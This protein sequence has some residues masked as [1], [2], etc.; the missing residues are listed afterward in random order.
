MKLDDRK[1]IWSWGLYDWANSAFATTV[2]AG[3]FPVFFKQYWSAG[4]DP[5]L[6]TARLGLANSVAGIMVALLAPLLG[7][8]ADQGSIRKKFLFFF[9]ALGVV[10]TSGL[11]L[12][13][14]GQWQFA[15][16]LFVLATV[17]F[18]GGNIFYDSLL[19]GVAS[20]KKMD[21]ISAL[22]FSLGYLGGGLLLAL[23]IS[24]ILKPS[25]FGLADTAAAVRTSFLMVAVW[26]TLFSVP[27][28]L[29]VKEPKKT[30]CRNQGMLL[31]GFQ[32]L[33]QT[34]QI[35]RKFKVLLFFLLAY[36]FYIDGVYTIVRMAVDYGLAIGL[37]ANDL[38][39][40]LL[41][42]QLV[43]FPA[44]ILFGYLGSRFGTKRAIFIAI[45]VYCA[46]TIWAA[47]MHSKHEFYL[48]A[49][50]IGLVQGGIQAL[51]RSF[52]AKLIPA[53]KSAE[54]FGFYNMVG[55][56]A[57]ILG[58]ALIGGVGLLLKTLGTSSD[59]AS[60][61][62]ITSIALLFITGGILFS[63]AKIENT[64]KK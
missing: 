28:F 3:F 47:F 29:F 33:R 40:A 41:I 59:L 17:G 11:Y 26:W 10:M 5:T 23:N 53:E 57:A 6:S 62:S 18:S 12:V 21:S 22:G 9:A 2:M 49:I 30:A 15:A 44:A 46:V 16:L 61:L 38:L 24:M 45:G 64:P 27:L 20:E 35:V 4:A 55:K 63:L 48:L 19:P 34:F 50:T 56:F 60:R 51:S 25:F 37:A 54:Y 32:E 39:L 31:A 1:A 42:T 8:I 43:S 13:S 7:A 36:W 58:P 52:Y 14:R